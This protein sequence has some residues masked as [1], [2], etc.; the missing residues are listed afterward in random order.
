MPIYE[1]R[2]P[3]CGA[4]FERFQKISDDSRPSC[5]VCGA[6]HVDRLI[7]A[8]A[9]HLKGSGWYVTDYKG[10]NAGN[11]AVQDGGESKPAATESK[12]AADSAPAAKSG[13]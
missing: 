7:S 2:C 13:D 12:P 1:Y 11:K 4:E 9:F 8:S 5:E 3:S 10:K 6:E